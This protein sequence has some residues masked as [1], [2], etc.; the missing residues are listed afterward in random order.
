MSVYR[1]S[2]LISDFSSLSPDTPGLLPISPRHC[3]RVF[4]GDLIDT[5]IDYSCIICCMYRT[6]AVSSSDVPISGWQSW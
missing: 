2:G 4:L 6:W 1:I 3:P 5:G